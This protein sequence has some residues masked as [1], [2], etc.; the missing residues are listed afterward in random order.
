VHNFRYLE[1]AVDGVGGSKEDVK[2]RTAA[3]RKKWHDLTAVM[4]DQQMSIAIKGKI[5]QNII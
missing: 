4:C 3:A 2:A 5:L 1:S